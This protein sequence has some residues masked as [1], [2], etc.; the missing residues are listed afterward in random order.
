MREGEK[1]SSRNE[2]LTQEPILRLRRLGSG[3]PRE[4]DSEGFVPLGVGSGR[5]GHFKGVGSFL[6]QA[7]GHSERSRR[8]RM[9][10]VTPRDSLD[11][12]ETFLQPM[13]LRD[14][15]ANEGT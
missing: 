7:R 9:A 12:T 5:I 4:A 1:N 13:S 15:H 3:Y 2:V 8:V 6:G 14:A 11:E 10:F